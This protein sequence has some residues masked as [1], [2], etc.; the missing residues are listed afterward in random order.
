MH[1]S[2]HG[3][4][5]GSPERVCHS[6]SDASTGQSGWSP[7]VKKQESVPSPEPARLVVFSSL[8]L[9]KGPFFSCVD[10]VSC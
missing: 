3:P 5:S 6:Q 2:G 10:C 9:S 4:K 1:R 7:F 8:P